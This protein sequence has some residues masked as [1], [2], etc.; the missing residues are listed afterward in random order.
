MLKKI[1]KVAFPTGG[2]GGVVCLT[3]Y[4]TNA[5]GSLLSSL[6]TLEIEDKPKVHEDELVP[7]KK[8]EPPQQQQDA[9]PSPPP[10][11][12]DENAGGGNPPSSGS[13]AESSGE[14]G[15]KGSEEGME[16][17]KVLRLLMKEIHGKHDTWVSNHKSLTNTYEIWSRIDNLKNV[18][19]KYEISLTAGE[20]KKE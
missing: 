14:K 9:P 3:M 12:G 13:P 17:E 2:V 1:A 8:P 20:G 11:G 5:N 16:I 6:E 19:N 15:A 18:L 7:E 4:L 10:S